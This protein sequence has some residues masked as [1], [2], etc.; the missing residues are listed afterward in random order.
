MFSI[1]L[2]SFLYHIFGVFIAWVIHV[3]IFLIYQERNNRPIVSNECIFFYT[4][5]KIVG[6]CFQFYQ[7]DC[8]C[9]TDYAHNIA[10]LLLLFSFISPFG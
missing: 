10:C 8:F 5:Y 9:G 7:E 1:V 4:L 2:V 3:L 6:L